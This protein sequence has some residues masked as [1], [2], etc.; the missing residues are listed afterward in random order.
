MWRKSQK[1]NIES[2]LFFILFIQVTIEVKGMAGHGKV[3][4]FLY[5]FLNFHNPG[6]TKLKYLLGIGAYHMVML[7]EAMRLFVQR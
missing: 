7:S 1:N 3:E 6:I 5:K 4:R 2:G